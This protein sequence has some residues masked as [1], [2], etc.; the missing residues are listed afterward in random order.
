MKKFSS[1]KAVTVSAHASFGLGMVRPCLLVS[2]RSEQEEADRSV[3][4]LINVHDGRPR[5]GRRGVEAHSPLPETYSSFL[6][7]PQC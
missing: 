6:N 1:N 3:Q 7:T 4:P 5:E 2:F